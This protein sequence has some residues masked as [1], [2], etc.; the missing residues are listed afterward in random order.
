[1]VPFSDRLLRCCCVT[2]QVLLLG[3]LERAM[4]V[5]KMLLAS[6]AHNEATRVL[7]LFQ[8]LSTYVEG[9]RGGGRISAHQ[10]QPLEHGLWQRQLPRDIG[11]LCVH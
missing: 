7:D 6:T 2:L 5:L 3:T 8:S 1:M 10:Q 11:V 4:E 9:K